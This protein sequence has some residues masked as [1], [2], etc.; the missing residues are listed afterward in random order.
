MRAGGIAVLL[1]SNEAY[2]SKC[3]QTIRALRTTGNYIGAIE[4][5]AF[6]NGALMSARM[7][8][9]ITNVRPLNVV[10][11]DTVPS[12]TPCTLLH[13]KRRSLNTSTAYLH[14]ALVTMSPWWRALY[15]VIL[16][17]DCGIRVHKSIKPLLGMA[18]AISHYDVPRFYAHSNAYPTYEWSLR[19]GFHRNCSTSLYAQL[20][21]EHN[22][23]SDYFQ[24]TVMLYDTRLLQNLSA[25]ISLYIRFGPIA[26]GDQDIL[27]L[28]YM[29]IVRHWTPL[30][31]GGPHC[32]Y[33]YLARAN[34]G[35]R[36]YILTKL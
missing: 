21:S 8:S 4:Y 32:Y 33:D 16:F 1:A 18:S 7:E 29:S 12:I 27:S 15:R 26:D 31:V 36:S 9:G 2:F 3:S 13:K 25:L 17:L 34:T 11:P 30:P 10:V 22:L 14:K 28:Y 20:K 6:D 24:S 5:V 19:T 35:C 23:N